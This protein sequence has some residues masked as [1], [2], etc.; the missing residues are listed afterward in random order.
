MGMFG[1]IKDQGPSQLFAEIHVDNAAN[2]GDPHLTVGPDGADV[3]DR[4]SVAETAVG[5]GLPHNRRWG[6]DNRGR[7]VEGL[8][9]FRRCHGRIALCR[10]VIGNALMRAVLVVVLPEAVELSLELLGCLGLWQHV[11]P[12]LHGGTAPACRRSEDGNGGS[13]SS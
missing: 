2:L 12:L 8:S 7:L 10:S 5:V 4:A 6:V 1:R 11:Q 9:R 13:G 3:D